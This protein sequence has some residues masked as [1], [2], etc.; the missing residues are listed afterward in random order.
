MWT[1]SDWLPGEVNEPS[2][3]LFSLRL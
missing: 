1:R 2:K 3:K